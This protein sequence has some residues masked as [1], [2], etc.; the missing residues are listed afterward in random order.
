MHT[1]FASRQGM[2]LHI[3]GESVEQDSYTNIPKTPQR[4]PNQ[5]P[6]SSL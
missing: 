5:N 2:S 1:W 4:K 3:I 6:P